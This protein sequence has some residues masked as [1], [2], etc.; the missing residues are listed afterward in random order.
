MNFQK[1]QFLA[2]FC[3]TILPLVYFFLKNP[4]LFQK[5]SLKLQLFYFLNYFLIFT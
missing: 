1:Q 3:L 4:N 5:T 2:P